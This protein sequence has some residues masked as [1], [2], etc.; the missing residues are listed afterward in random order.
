MSKADKE[1]LP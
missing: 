1:P